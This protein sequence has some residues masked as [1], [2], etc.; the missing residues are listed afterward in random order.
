MPESALHPR[1][2]SLV[3]TLH[4]VHVNRFLESAHTG[5]IR[6]CPSSS[7]RIAR[8]TERDSVVERVCRAVLEGCGAEPRRV[9]MWLADRLLSAFVGLHG[10]ERRCTVRRGREATWRDRI[11]GLWR[12]SG[13]GD[14]EQVPQPRSQAVN[15]AR[16]QSGPG[17]VLIAQGHRTALGAPRES[18]TARLP[19][20]Q[21]CDNLPVVGR[22][23]LGGIHT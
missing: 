15:S 20:L 9:F 21:P 17:T 22:L 1:I 4:D 18:L 19:W 16:V 5:G 3:G 14:G 23:E 2:A 8:W 13:C 7:R 12:D 6:C 11:A 10:Y